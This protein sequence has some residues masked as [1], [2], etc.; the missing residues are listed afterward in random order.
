MSI[1]KII[2]YSFSF[3]FLGWLITSCKIVEPPQLPPAAQLPSTFEGSRDT[4]SM[5]DLG[6]PEFFNDS[7]LVELID[8]ALQ[9]NLDLLTTVQRIEMARANFEI[10]KAELLPSVDVRFRGRTGDL[11]TPLLEN[12]INGV[13]NIENQT[14]DYFLGFQSFWEADLWGKLRNRRK[15][16]YVRFLASEKGQH[17][18]T[19]ALV[20][21]VA[22]M[23]Y[24]L[25]GLDIELE[26]IEKNIGLQEIALEMIKIQKI[27]GR[28]TELAVQQFHA[29]LLRT[30][31]L[32]F[33]KR[34][35]IIEVE[36]QLNLLLGR[37][38]QPITRGESIIKQQLPEMI[39]AGIP[40][41]LLLRRPD[42][43]QAEMQL[44]AAKADLEAARA[45]FLPSFTI[46]PYAGLHGGTV[47]SVFNTPQSLIFGFITGV[48]APIFLNK[49]IRAGY[50]QSVARNMEAFYSYQSSIINGY[51]EVVS[52][53]NR[54]DN[55]KKIYD[56]REQETDVLLSAVSTSNDLYSAGYA[57]YLEVITAQGRV[58][59]A[60]L[61]MTNTRK[62][63]FLSLI[64]LYRALGGGWK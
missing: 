9:N 61:S 31:G 55:Y 14:Q 8:I 35:R 42:I 21:E 17:L 19:T 12:N 4:I 59:E 36:N 53:L 50:N 5:G 62:E 28:A 10:R 30:Q 16:A 33:E 15:A 37:Y 18:V 7:R 6:W 48:T 60:E 20:A 46:T 26:T 58:L 40:S 3:F 1:K 64:D 49:R 41:D 47:P 13:I 2:N 51:Q 39:R 27:G 45:E 22:R 23:Y 38:P 29:Q 54:V 52:S 43:Q 44:L 25:L 32:G 24:E 63:I 11:T 56:L 34:Q 57:S